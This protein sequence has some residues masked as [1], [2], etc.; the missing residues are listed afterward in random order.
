MKQ[1]TNYTVC[2]F[3]QAQQSSF[4]DMLSTLVGRYKPVNLPVRL[5]FFGSPGDNEEYCRQFATIR[6]AV[7]ERFGPQAPT[8]SYVAQPPC[9]GG[10]I[11][12]IHE[13]ETTPY[14]KV[15]YKTLACT[16]YITITGAEGKRLFLS[17][18][19]G[20]C[21]NNSMRVQSDNVFAEIET[22]LNAEQMPV[23]SIFRQWNYIEKITA[24]EGSRQHYQSFNDSRSLFY[25]TGLWTEGYPAATGIGTCWGGIMI[26]LNAAVLTD[27][28]YRI[29]RI[30]NPLQVAAHAYS[31]EVLLGEEDQK[32]KEK[33]TPKFERAK[34]IIKDGHGITY[35]S[36]TAAIRGE[37]SLTDVG[38][39]QQTIITLENIRK[40]ISCEN[41]RSF[42]MSPCDDGTPVYFRVYLKN[43]S[44]YERARQTIETFY[45][46]LPVIYTLAD[47]CRSELLVEIEGL[48]NY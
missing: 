15:A 28:S 35:I 21:L 3:V 31:Q 19:T 23:S 24:F 33:S 10:L 47:V 26:D 2:R 32:L 16:T 36:G 39:E 11:L 41:L 29:C 27:S 38:I 12:E 1:F 46:A 45:P 42:G 48:A 20:D 30:D 14:D 4:I 37:L 22:V 13:V 18:V 44:D 6:Q 7:E 43:A 9:S 25:S 17:G 34:S 8:V 40:L 5:V